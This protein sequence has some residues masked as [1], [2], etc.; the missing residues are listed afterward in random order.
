MSSAKE[1]GEVHAFLRAFRGPKSVPTPP[2]RADDMH[3]HMRKGTH[4]HTHMRAQVPTHMHIS[5]ITHTPTQAPGKAVH[6]SHG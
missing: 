4:T 2:A 3:A 6:T 1:G 5:G